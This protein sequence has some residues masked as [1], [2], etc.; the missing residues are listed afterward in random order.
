[1]PAITLLLLNPLN[2]KCQFTTKSQTF[3]EPSCYAFSV[4]KAARPIRWF[5]EGR[6]VPLPNNWSNVLSLADNKA[7]L[8]RF[9]SEELCSQTMC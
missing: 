8:G 1:M 2:H 5:V 9:V 6:A 3:N 7:D 4:R